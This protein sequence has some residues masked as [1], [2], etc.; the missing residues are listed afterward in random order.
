MFSLAHSYGNILREGWKD[1][2]DC[3]LALFKARLLPQ[4]MV[5]VNGCR[6]LVALHTL[7]RIELVGHESSDTLWCTSAC[8]LKKGDQT[9]LLLVWKLLVCGSI[10][11][12]VKHVLIG[13]LYPHD[14][15]FLM[16]SGTSLESRVLLVPP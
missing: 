16:Y 1:L 7:M 4:P 14:K 6:S 8:F 12:L 2:L 3:L 9:K 15:D 10:L 13:L 11:F 5:E